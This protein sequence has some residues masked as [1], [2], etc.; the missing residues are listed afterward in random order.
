M[1]KFVRRGCGAEGAA[2]RGGAAQRIYPRE[3]SRAPSDSV[4]AAPEQD[5]REDSRREDLRLAQHLRS[6]TQ[7][8]STIRRPIGTVQMPAAADTRPRAQVRRRAARSARSQGAYLLGARETGVWRVKSCSARHVRRRIEVLHGIERQVVL[9][10]KSTPLSAA[11]HSGGEERSLMSGRGALCVA[12][13]PVLC[14]QSPG[15]RRGTNASSHSPSESAPPSLFPTVE[16]RKAHFLN[17]GSNQTRNVD[18]RRNTHW[19]G[20]ELACRSPNA[21]I[22]FAISVTTTTELAK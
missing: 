16:A 7:K 2:P 5:H 22:A 8:R 21:T 14:T 1:I 9:R 19:P 12:A 17:F 18:T 3:G 10:Q 13:S 6:K 15:R 20:P 11:A 4:Q